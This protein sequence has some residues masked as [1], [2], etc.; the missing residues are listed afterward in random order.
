MWWRI[1]YNIISSHG[2]GSGT[3]HKALTS[4][5]CRF[6]DSGKVR[7]ARES[8]LSLVTDRQDCFAP[9]C[10]PYFTNEVAPPGHCQGVG[11][12]A[13]DVACSVFILSQEMLT[14]RKPAVLPASLW[15]G[16]SSPAEGLYPHP[17]SPFPQAWLLS[18]G[19]EWRKHKDAS[20]SPWLSAT[21]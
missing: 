9:P 19:T 8:A 10:R 18:A 16:I 2:L 5:L 20:P 3:C 6:K 4:V 15:M 14:S 17:R 21:L 12:F 7:G 1:I 13:L 11:C